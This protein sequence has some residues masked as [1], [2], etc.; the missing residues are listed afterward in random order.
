MRMVMVLIKDFESCVEN[1]LLFRKGSAHSSTYTSSGKNLYF[2]RLLC[3]IVSVTLE[4][5]MMNVGFFELGEQTTIL[6]LFCCLACSRTTGI[7][8]S[9]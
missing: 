3:A 5:H 9:M 4:L 2:L 7:Y 8:Y 1:N 6:L